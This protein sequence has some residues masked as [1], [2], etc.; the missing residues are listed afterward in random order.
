MQRTATF[1]DRWPKTPGNMPTIG[2]MSRVNR[3]DNESG[4]CGS[5]QAMPVREEAEGVGGNS[6]ESSCGC[7]PH[8]AKV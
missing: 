6:E 7:E 2:L 4:R 1:Y 5:D 3:L 8:P